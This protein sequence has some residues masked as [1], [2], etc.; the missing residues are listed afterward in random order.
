MSG[1]GDGAGLDCRVAYGVF[2]DCQVDVLF[3][4]TAEN[5]DAVVNLFQSLCDITFCVVALDTGVDR[6]RGNPQNVISLSLIS[7]SSER[8]SII[9]H[10]QEV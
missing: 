3:G 4:F 10:P 8:F 7:R 9:L 5:V 6:F 2:L 1:V